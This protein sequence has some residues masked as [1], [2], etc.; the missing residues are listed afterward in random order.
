[1]FQGFSDTTIDFMWGVRFNN[2]KSWFEAH[3]Q[4]YIDSFYE[5]MKVLGKELWT[6]LDE[7]H[8]DLG[9]F[10]KVSRIYRDARRLHG[11]GPYKDHLWFCIR[12]PGEHWVDRPT[13]WFELG[14]EQ[15]SYG[16]GY[17]CAETVTMA[18][19]RARLDRDPKKAEKLLR[20]LEGQQ[21]FVLTG[22]SYK[23]EKAAP[24]AALAQWYNMKNFSFEHTEAN[25][26]VLYDHSLADRLFEGMNFLMP[27]YR[28]LAPISG[29]P[30]PRT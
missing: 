28:Y 4:E 30:D 12:A 24:T 10:C 23:K 29:D 15:W 2:E 21:E 22:P 11:R 18:K 8:P 27:F 3:K 25:S 20:T 7:A 19:F 26:D 16:L 6:R 14:P 9:L 5:P 13:F 1:M 17:Y